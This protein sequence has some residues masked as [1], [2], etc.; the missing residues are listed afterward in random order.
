MV[1]AAKVGDNIPELTTKDDK[2]VFALAALVT[3]TVY[4]FVV[5]PS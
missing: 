2:S 5:V 4:V 3:V 1:P